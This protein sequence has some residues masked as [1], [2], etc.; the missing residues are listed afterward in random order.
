MIQDRSPRPASARPAPV[1]LAVALLA[2]AALAGCSSSPSRSPSAPSP[3]ASST[4]VPGWTV[5]T[6][7]DHSGGAGATGAAGPSGGAASGGAAA[8]AASPAPAAPPSGEVS[9]ERVR[10]VPRSS[11]GPTR[12]S[13]G[14][15]VWMISRPPGAPG[16]YA[17][18][19]HLDG[20][21]RRILQSYAF[22]GV[23]PQWLLVTPKAVYCG[24]RGDG[25]APDAM[26]CRVDR[27][28][29]ELRVR[30]SADLTGH[31]AV[32]EGDLAGR[33][34]AWALDDRNFTADLGA[35]PVL[36]TELT[37]R[38]GGVLRLDPDTLTVLGS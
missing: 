34:G 13:T 17:D 11:G 12:A 24:R 27:A 5:G 1:A 28:T 6:P 19:L 23:A 16:S 21:G 36:G 32:G 38:S 9:P 20:S 29:G 8:G 7:D 33:P 3:A 14:D 30:V 26:V 31:P 10:Q 37:F 35:A 25:A 4:T 15:G 2:A 22:P 18:L